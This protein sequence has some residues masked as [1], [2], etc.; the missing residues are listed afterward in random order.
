V[1]AVRHSSTATILWSDNWLV[2]AWWL[3]ERRPDAVAH[4]ACNLAFGLRRNLWWR[5]DSESG[6]CDPNYLDWLN[7]WKFNC[8]RGV[9][10]PLS[11]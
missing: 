3:I 6:L 10:W 4:S 7:Y 1:A 11:R 9:R 5:V 2:E 8:T